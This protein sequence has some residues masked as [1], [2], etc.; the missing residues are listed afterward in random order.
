MS[1][2][3]LTDLPGRRL[4]V[5]SKILYAL[6]AGFSISLYTA[7]MGALPLVNNVFTG[8]LAVYSLWMTT[9]QGWW[10]QVRARKAILLWV[11]FYVWNFVSAWLSHNQEQGQFVMHLRLALVIFPLTVGTWKVSPEVKDR[12]LFC[13]G[14]VTT[15]AALACLGYAFLQ[16]RQTGDSAYLYDDSLS[17]LSSIQSVYFALMVELAVFAYGYLLIKRSP[18]LASRVWTVVCIVFLL[19]IHFMLASRIGIIL[20]YSTLLVLGGWY[21]VLRGRAMAATHGRTL[22]RALAF[23]ALVLI[24]AAALMVLFPK[25]LNRFHE[26]SYTDYHFDSH[27]RESH[28][29]MQVTPDQWNGANIR[30]AIWAC[31]RTVSARHLWTG[32][33]VGDKLDTLVGQYRA[34]HFD[35][36]ADN[37]RNT[38]NTYLDVLLCFGLPG[39]ALFVAGFIGVPLWQLARQKNV[40]GIIVVITFAVSM[41]TETYIDRSLGCTLL[42]FWMWFVYD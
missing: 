10:A 33:P 37:R 30:L 41:I 36:A 18:L 39:L 34:V 31:A 2:L 25:T 6:T 22:K 21:F 32:V 9:R 7:P 14:T 12:M 16:Y 11:A 26:L 3:F 28:Y 5:S 23:F 38:H 42:G 1:A 35:F 19:G 29:N 27:G 15:L 24:A 17:Q 8:A 40:L 4:P 13:Y 20:L